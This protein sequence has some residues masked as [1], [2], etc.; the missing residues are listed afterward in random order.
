MKQGGISWSVLQ[1]GNKGVRERHICKYCGRR[2]KMNWAKENHEKL[3][4]E[5]HKTTKE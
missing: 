2:Y 5:L 1:G 3:C 4:K